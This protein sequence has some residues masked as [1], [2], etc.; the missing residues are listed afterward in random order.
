MMHSFRNFLARIAI[1]ERQ[2]LDLVIGGNSFQK[3]P[4]GEVSLPIRNAA[5]AV[6]RV[7][8]RCGEE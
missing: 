4:P 8:F 2:A 6:L 5:T 1:N 3:M 7:A